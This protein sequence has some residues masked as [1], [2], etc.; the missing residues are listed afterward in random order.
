[1]TSLCLLGRGIRKVVSIC[2]EIK[3]L[4]CESDMH[5]TYREDP[6]DEDVNNEFIGLDEETV[7]DL[8]REYVFVQCHCLCIWQA[9]HMMVTSWERSFIAVRELN[10]LIPNFY[11]RIDE[12]LPEDLNDFYAEVRSISNVILIPY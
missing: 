7:V 11:K 10:R 4:V 6:D 1:M 2:G 12:G 5:R 3:D 9:N 8:K